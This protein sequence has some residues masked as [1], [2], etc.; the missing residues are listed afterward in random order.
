MRTVIGENEL[1]KLPLSFFSLDGSLINGG[2]GKS[3]TIVEVLKFGNTKPLAQ[4]SHDFPD[5]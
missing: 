2:V 5:F 1:T 3:N 4:V